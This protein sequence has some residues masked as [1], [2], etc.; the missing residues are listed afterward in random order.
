MIAGAKVSVSAQRI[1]L[2]VD[3]KFTQRVIHNISCD[4]HKFIS[5]QH[6]TW[7]GLAPPTSTPLPVFTW[8]LVPAQLASRLQCTHT[9]VW[10]QEHMLPFQQPAV[11]SKS[12]PQMNKTSKPVVNLC[13]Q[14]WMVQIIMWQNTQWWARQWINWSNVYGKCCDH[15]F[16]RS[17][18]SGFLVCLVVQWVLLLPV[19]LEVLAPPSCP[20][21]L[22]PLGVPACPEG[23]GGRRDQVVLE[24]L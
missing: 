16:Q 5:T 23:L 15:N 9:G 19:S 2:H 7:I 1:L 4:S 17:L 24:D 14:V 3:F 10:D 12:M 11:K 18:L 20:S 13:V 22:G 6:K 21:L 8:L